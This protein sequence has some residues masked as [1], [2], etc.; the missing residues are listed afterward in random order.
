MR[1][2]SI[3]RFI[4]FASLAFILSA[5][6]SEKGGGLITAPFVPPTTV[7]TGGSGSF[8]AGGGGWEIGKPLSLVTGTWTGV[9]TASV[10][11]SGTLS[12]TFTQ[13]PTPDGVVAATLSWTSATTSLTFHGT[14]TGTLSA[15]VITATDGPV[16]G[17][18]YNATGSLNPAGT[19]I[20]GSY[21]GAGPG[22]C[23]TKAGTFVLNGQSY[24]PPACPQEFSYTGPA[25]FTLAN[26]GDATELAYIHDHVNALLTGPTKVEPGGKSW[27]SDGNYPAVLVKSGTTYAIFVNVTTGQV[28][29]SPGLNPQGKQQ[30][31][32]HVSKFVCPPVVVS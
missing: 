9:E 3:A 13:S 26:S 30:D 6:S 27:T 29:Q 15:M 1:V 23:P 5:C 22:A 14:L 2:F 24:V 7:K 11:Q 10:G 21:T 8:G 17:C 28:L 31:I 20:T 32:S 18:S 19:Q 4:S 12:V 16:G 25:T